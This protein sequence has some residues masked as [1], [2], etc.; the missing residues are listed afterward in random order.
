M[1]SEFL[2]HEKLDLG[3]KFCILQ[4]CKAASLFEEPYFGLNIAC[5]SVMLEVM[6]GLGR[7]CLICFFSL[8]LSIHISIYIYI[9]IYIYIERERERERNIYRVT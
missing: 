4:N 1:S 9:Y 2:C 8:S 5:T 7:Y 3:S 6:S